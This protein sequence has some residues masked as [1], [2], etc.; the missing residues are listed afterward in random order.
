M[1]GHW[2]IS[3]GVTP[4]GGTPFNVLIEDRANG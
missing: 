2:G 3:Y 1:V 4:P